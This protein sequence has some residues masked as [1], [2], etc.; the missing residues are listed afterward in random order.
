[1]D[2]LGGKMT[3]EQYYRILGE[4]INK[5]ST[6]DVEYLSMLRLIYLYDKKLNKNSK[7]EEFDKINQKAIE[8]YY[9][10]DDDKKQDV[11]ASLLNICSKETKDAFLNAKDNNEGLYK[12]HSYIVEQELVGKEDQ[13]ETIKEARK[14]EAREL[15]TKDVKEDYI[16]AKEN[17]QMANK[18][19]YDKAVYM[20]FLAGRGL[21]DSE[22]LTEKLM[23]ISKASNS[24]LNTAETRYFTRVIDDVVNE[25]CR[26]KNGA[27]DLKIEIR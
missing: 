20:A 3:Q 4:K 22:K 9:T 19:C 24:K 27:N 13:K 5:D 15:E 12:I 21:T 1:M 10:N 23:S 6:S 17:A 16:T 11:I 25:D 18:L 8:A 26:L 2:L 7:D 14:I